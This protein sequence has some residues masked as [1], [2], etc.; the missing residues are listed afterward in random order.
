MLKG[1]GRQA[2]RAFDQF[3]IEHFNTLDRLYGDKM[4]K[5]SFDLSKALRIRFVN[6]V[7]PYWMLEQYRLNNP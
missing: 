3:R 1:F 4:T 7:I 2:D 6:S 5:P